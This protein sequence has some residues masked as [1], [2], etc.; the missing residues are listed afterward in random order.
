MQTTFGVDQ[1]G[2]RQRSAESSLFIELLRSFIDIAWR[3]C[4]AHAVRIEAGG[5]RAHILE[6]LQKALDH[7]EQSSN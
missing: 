6:G 1:S 3:S 7:I 5:A 4:A 2:D